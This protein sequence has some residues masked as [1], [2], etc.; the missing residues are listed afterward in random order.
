M[1]NENSSVVNIYVRN[2][3]EGKIT[4]EQVPD[5]FNLQEVIYSILDE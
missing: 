2:I 4:K 1:F 5:L 3:K